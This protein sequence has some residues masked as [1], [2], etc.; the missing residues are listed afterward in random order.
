M[1]VSWGVIKGSSRGGIA[2]RRGGRCQV[3]VDEVQCA[4]T[5]C[6]LAWH[7]AQIRGH[8]LP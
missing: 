8:K 5:R 6:E 1:D 4:D 2:G 7:S 3:E